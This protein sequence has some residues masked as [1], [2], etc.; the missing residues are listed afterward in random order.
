M[1]LKTYMAILWRRKWIIVIVTAV[2]VIITTVGTFMLTPT[3]EAT[4]T[5]FIATTVDGT[6]NSGQT[7]YADRLKKTYRVHRSCHHGRPW[8]SEPHP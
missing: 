8:G 3:Y 7:N 5:L 2:T 4:A 1:E 6:Y